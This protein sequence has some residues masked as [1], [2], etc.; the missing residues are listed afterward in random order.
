MSTFLIFVAGLLIGWLIEWVID[1][2]YWRR[3]NADLRHQLHDTQSSAA[4]GRL[5]STEI[6]RMRQEL[7]AAKEQAGHYEAEIA[8]LSAANN[9]TTTDQTDSAD[10]EQCQQELVEAQDQIIRY[11][12]KLKEFDTYHQKLSEAESEIEQLK[13]ELSQRSGQTA[14][15]FERVIIKDNLERIN[16]IGPV[17]A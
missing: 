3:V 6:E 14:H 13:A 7:D 8:R 5:T 10:I 15:T 2:L 16:G 11:Q 4:V 1:W 17:F 9:H 12:S